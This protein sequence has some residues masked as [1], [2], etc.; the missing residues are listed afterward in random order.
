MAGY[1]EDRWRHTGDDYRHGR[2][3]RAERGGERDWSDRASD[4]VRSWFGD[5]DAERRRRADERRAGYST[6]SRRGYDEDDIFYG[7]YRGIEGQRNRDGGYGS[8]SRGGY[9]EDVFDSADRGY[10]GAPYTQRSAAGTGRHRGRGPKNYTRSDDRIREDVSDRLSDDAHL[11]ASDIE[12]SVNNGEVTLNGT[13]D[14]RFAKRHAEDI[15]ESVSGVSHLQNNLRV[16]QR[17]AQTEDTTN[18]SG[19][20]GRVSASGGASANA[21]R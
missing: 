12:V 15:A 13:V 4:E 2:G 11:D 3:R 18:E 17:T 20:V 19:G 5:D 16:A 10:P 9:R 21:R 8:Y 6:G 7:A 14:E 1:P